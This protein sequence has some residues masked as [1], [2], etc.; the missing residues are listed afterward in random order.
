MTTL[1]GDGR[2][3]PEAARIAASGHTSALA[4]HVHDH[5]DLAL[6]RAQIHH[7]AVQGFQGEVESGRGRFAPLEA[8]GSRQQDGQDKTDSEW[9]QKSERLDMRASASPPHNNPASTENTI[10]GFS[11]R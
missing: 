6:V 10:L 9:K 11:L 1:M 4:G 5:H 8:D 7:L 2:A 3:G